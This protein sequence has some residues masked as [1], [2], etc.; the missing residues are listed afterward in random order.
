VV[1]PGADPPDSEA[2]ARL[3]AEEADASTDE[4]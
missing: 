4:A 3:A 1:P 2:D